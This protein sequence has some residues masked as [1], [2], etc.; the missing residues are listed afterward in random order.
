MSDT[1]RTD[2]AREV[3]AGFYFPEEKV[4]AGFARQ[5]ERE[6][7]ALRADK[8]RLDWIETNARLTRKVGY[9]RWSFEGPECG[10]VRG[11]IDIARGKEAQP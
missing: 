11:S 6:N 4:P 9:L 1:P 10:T 3:P 5:L 2:G 8:E 7:A